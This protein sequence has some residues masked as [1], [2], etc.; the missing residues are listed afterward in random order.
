M[1]KATWIL[2]FESGQLL[3]L[4]RLYDFLKNYTTTTTTGHNKNVSFLFLSP[5][6]VEW[7]RKVLL[8]WCT[9]G[10]VYPVSSLTAKKFTTGSGAI[11]A[12]PYNNRPSRRDMRTLAHLNSY[13]RAAT[14][15]ISLDLEPFRW[16][17]DETLNSLDQ[18]HFWWYPP[19]HIRKRIVYSTK[20]QGSIHATA[21][22]RNYGLCKSTLL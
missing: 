4:S 20:V 8:R 1:L 16:N 3:I 17:Q 10:F 15:G 14:A 19:T 7:P 5:R 18:T 21:G 12:Y 22:M 13:N 9:K 11:A 2:L 6:R